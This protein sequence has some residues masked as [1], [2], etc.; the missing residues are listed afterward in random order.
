MFTFIKIHTSCLKCLVNTL[1][2]IQSPR[3][4]Q[5]PALR[6]IPA[7]LTIAK[8]GITVVLQVPTLQ[9]LWSAAGEQSNAIHQNAI[10][11]EAGKW[12]AQEHISTD[13]LNG[14][15]LE[16][17]LGGGFWN[18]FV[19]YFQER[20]PTLKHSRKVS[21]FRTLKSQ[22]WH[23]AFQCDF[24]QDPLSS[25]TYMIRCH[26]IPCSGYIFFCSSPI[27]YFLNSFPFLYATCSSL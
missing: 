19:C 21:N 25:S 17:E 9:C 15:I 18:Q 20:V 8:T 24:L 4:T 27:E 6:D 12:G 11:H 23:V 14:Q 1:R 3:C 22:T 16:L 5:R 13:H 10:S 2:L 26:F 7:T